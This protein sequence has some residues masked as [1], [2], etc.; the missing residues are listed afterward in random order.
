MSA[1]PIEK[2]LRARG[3][4]FTRFL[5]REK[6]RGRTFSSLFLRDRRERF[7][8][9]RCSCETLPAEEGSESE[10]QAVN[11]FL[12]NR[13]STDKQL[14]LPQGRGVGAFFTGNKNQRKRSAFI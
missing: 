8:K 4:F 14:I 13:A 6:I 1:L 7:W 9:Y 10:I 2:P 5:L 11:F 3:G 12:R